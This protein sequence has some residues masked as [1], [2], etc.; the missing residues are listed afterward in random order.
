MVKVH[1]LKTDSEFFNAVLTGSKTFEIRFNDRNFMVGDELHLRET[2]NSGE[3]MKAGLPLVYTGKCIAV[4][5]NYVLRG[6]KYG[7]VDGW[8][9][10]SI[11]R[12]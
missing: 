8:V 12:I 7:L 4:E 1:E 5:V 9:I 6:Q 10:M 3:E 11:E 2:L